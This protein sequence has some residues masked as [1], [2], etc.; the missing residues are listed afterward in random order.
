MEK[1][2]KCNLGKYRKENNYKIVLYGGNPNAKIMLIGEAPGKEEAI[3]GEPF[4]GRAGK[5]LRNILSS[6][7]IDANTDLFIVNT[8]LCRPPENRNPTKE[9]QKACFPYIKGMFFIVKPKLVITAGRVASDWLS[10][11]I[12]QEYKIYDMQEAT[13]NDYSFYWLPMYH[14]SYLLRN[15]SAITPFINALHKYRRIIALLKAK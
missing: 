2:F 3:Q 13:W 6:Q 1:C 5:K 7:S 4:I 8:V 10:R 14:P 15:P 12:N 11:A 9:E